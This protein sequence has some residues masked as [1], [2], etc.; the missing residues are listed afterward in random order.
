MG[1]RLSDR[2]IVLTKVIKEIP[3]L[4]EIVPHK[5]CTSVDEVFEEFN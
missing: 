4:V 5:L 1:A 2:K 3:G